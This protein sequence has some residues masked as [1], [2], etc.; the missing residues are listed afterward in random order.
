MPYGMGEYRTA[1]HGVDRSNLLVGR[2]MERLKKEAA[3]I[4]A[5]QAKRGG[6]PPL[7]DGKAGERIAGILA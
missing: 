6:I 4:L 5:G 3:A 1:R 7:W 2:D